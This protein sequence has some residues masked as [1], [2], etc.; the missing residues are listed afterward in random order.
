MEKQCLV[1]YIT[2]SLPQQ[3]LAILLNISIIT[4][5]TLNFTRRIESKYIRELKKQ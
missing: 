3:D 1:I 5:V 2:R 4:F